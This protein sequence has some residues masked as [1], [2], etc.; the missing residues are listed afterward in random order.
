MHAAL[1][2][3]DPSVVCLWFVPPWPMQ[4]SPGMLLH[5]PQRMPLV[6]SDQG[7][8]RLPSAPM[9]SA[10]CGQRQQ[11][12]AHLCK[13]EL[14]VQ[15]QRLQRPGDLGGVGGHHAGDPLPQQAL[16][17]VGF[18]GDAGVR[19]RTGV[20]DMLSVCSAAQPQPWR[21]CEQSVS[22]HPQIGGSNAVVGCLLERDDE[23]HATAPWPH[24]CSGTRIKAARPHSGTTLRPWLKGGQN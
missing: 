13:G 14:V 7:V 1:R 17:A 9:P 10:P 23:M 15:L 16:G 24:E 6:S 5:T 22:R 19:L 2:S 4:S 21:Q 12:S 11:G 20:A 3:C 18:C 8:R